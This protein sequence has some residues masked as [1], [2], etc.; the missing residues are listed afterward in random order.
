MSILQIKIYVFP[1]KKSHLP[2]DIDSGRA[3]I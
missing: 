1:E 3:G 2:K